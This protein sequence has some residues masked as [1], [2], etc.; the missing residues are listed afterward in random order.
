MRA[1]TIG[2]GGLIK[3]TF[4]R[5]G[6]DNASL[7][8]A[9]LAYTAVFAIAPLIVIAV[10]VA[11]E[12][13]GWTNGGHGHHVAEDQIISA[14]TATAGTQ[15]ATLV[16]TLV[17]T[18]FR[19]HQGSLIAQTLGWVTFALAASG[20]F[21]TLQ[22][23]MNLVWQTSPKGG[24]WLTVRNRLLSA[25]M[26]LVLGVL[27]LV[28]IG[29]DVALAFVW[30]HLD[31]VL[32]FPGSGILATI[33]SYLVDVVLIALM[34][35]LVYKV[36]PD[37]DVS[38]SD[39]K[40]GAPVTAALFVGGE[41]LLSLYLSRAGIANAYGAVGSLVVLL[42]WVYYSSMLFLLGAEF[43]RAYAERRHAAPVVA[44]PAPAPAA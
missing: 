14:I 18:T 1:M 41:A 27:L 43:T 11:G 13:I 6:R 29:I 21:L 23:V 40:V 35:A 17:D 42:V 12:V 44:V 20:L 9:A 38:W 26:L 5:F 3:D 10:A 4:S 24:I 34:F 19:S 33:A 37:A 22:S 28:T 32:P 36:L 15:A 16:R 7:L 39:V 30:S 8:A 25:A 2:A 31:A